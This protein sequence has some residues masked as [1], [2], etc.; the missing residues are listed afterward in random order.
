MER[1]HAYGAA[2]PKEK[3][4][5]TA[6]R[7]EEARFRRRGAPQPFRKKRRPPARTALEIETDPEFEGVLDLGRPEGVAEA[8]R[9][10]RAAEV[11][12]ELAR[13][14]VAYRVAGRDGFVVV[15]G[16]LTL[17]E[18]LRWAWTCVAEYSM[19]RHTNLSVLHGPQP[20]LWAAACAAAEG[21]DFT[22]FRKLRWASL[23]YHYDWNARRYD[24]AA[25][26][27]F[28]PAL[29]GLAASLAA[30]AGWPGMRAEAALCNYYPNK[31]YMGP[32]VDDAELTASAP[33]VSLSLGNSCVFLMGG[34]SLDERPVPVMLRSGDAAVMGGGSRMGYHAVPRIV[35]DTFRPDAARALGAASE[36]GVP[37]PAAPVLL[38]YLATHRINLNV[39]QVEGDTAEERFR[40]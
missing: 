24:P 11:P 6:F 35:A 22:A 19:E 8:L 25:V 39:R 37:A 12:C 10:G 28:P 20:D 1:G 5:K 13:G 16:A 27:P 34:A 9:E 40:P 23:G 4:D 15:P 32:H 29:A 2:A 38:E 18:Q 21:G 17:R 30:S 31:A 36:A 26:T 3:A 7:L 33:V 14:G